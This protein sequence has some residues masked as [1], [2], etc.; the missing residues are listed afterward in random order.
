MR[1]GHERAGAMSEGPSNRS[2]G[3]VFSAFFAVV[4]LWPLVGGGPVRL[5]SIGVAGALLIVVLVRPSV[6][7]YPNRWW[8]RFG[9]MLH[10]VTSPIILGV[11]FFVVVAP[12]GMVRRRFGADPLL[13][14]KDKDRPSYWERRTPPGPPPDNMTDQF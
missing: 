10:A 12:V 11:I 9:E 8:M 6:L 3:M 13:L 5:W 14:R 7:T 4:G 2:F 1:Q